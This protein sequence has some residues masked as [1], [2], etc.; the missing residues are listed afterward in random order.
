MPNKCIGQITVWGG[1]LVKFNNSIVPNNSIGANCSKQIIVQCEKVTSIFV[2]FSAEAIFYLMQSQ[3]W[4]ENYVD[5]HVF[6]FS[7]EYA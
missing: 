1:K 6:F 4:L 3:G 7:A 5:C 2:F